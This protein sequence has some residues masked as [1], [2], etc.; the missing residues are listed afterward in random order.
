MET[1]ASG[2]PAFLT[3]YFA[4]SAGPSPCVA[5]AAAGEIDR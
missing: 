2:C 1:G 5:G 3:G 4:P